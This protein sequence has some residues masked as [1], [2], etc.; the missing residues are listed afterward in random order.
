MADTVGGKNVEEAEAHGTD[1]SKWLGSGKTIVP[2]YRY[3]NEEDGVKK[4]FAKWIKSKKESNDNPNPDEH[5]A[6]KL[7]KKENQRSALYESME[8]TPWKIIM[9]NVRGLI[10]A[11]SRETIQLID[12]YANNEKIV[13]MNFTETWLDKTIKEEADI[14][15]FHTYRCDRTSEIARGG[16]AIYLFDKIEAGQIWEKRF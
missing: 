7:D 6:D 8:K 14:E 4:N 11:E 13:L 5:P 1:G 3:P 2:M 9:Q 15:G 10:T 12:D 16:V